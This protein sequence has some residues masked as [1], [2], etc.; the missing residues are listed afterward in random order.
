MTTPR[1]SV[2]PDYAMNDVIDPSS[3]QPNVVEPPTGKKNGGWVYNE[4]P[5]RQYFNWLSRMTSTWLHYADEQITAILNAL[6]NIITIPIG[7]VLSFYGT[8]VPTNY[9][10]CDGSI[11]S[12]TT[13]PD[14]YTLLGGNTLP[15]LRG[16]FLVGYKS[17]DT[18]YNA[19]GKSGGEKTHQ[20]SVAEL[21]PHYH[22]IEG[23]KNIAGSITGFERK[24][25]AAHDAYVSSETAGSG[26][27][28]ENRPQFITVQYII[29]AK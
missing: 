24:T 5:P 26:L 27:S 11:F 18:D 17:T 3:G 22:D 15:D 19:I 6:S 10:T 20:L 2:F 23:T 1:P 21:P 4:K 12:Q 9:L 14:L 7:T 13:Y 28:H 8:S 25:N 16:Q 29:R